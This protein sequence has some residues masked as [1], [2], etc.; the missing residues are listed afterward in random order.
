MRVF[1]FPYKSF[2]EHFSFKEEFSEI[3]FKI[4]PD[5]V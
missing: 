5:F 3:V 1:I 2:L 4:A